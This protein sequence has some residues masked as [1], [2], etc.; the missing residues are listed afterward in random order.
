MKP[1]KIYTGRSTIRMYNC[2]CMELLNSGKT[3]D[4]AIVDPPY[5]IGMDSRK[6]NNRSSKGKYK[7]KQSQYLNK[8]WD[9]NSPNKWYH[10]KLKDISKNQIVW[11]A[12]YL[13]RGVWYGNK[14][15][16]WY[17]NGQSGA[18]DS[19]DCELACTSLDGLTVKM[20]TYDWV[21][22][23]AINAKEKRIHPTQ[24]P[25]QLYKWLLTNYAKEGDTI[26]D[27]HGGSMSIA[28]A[29][30][31]LGFDLDICELDTDYF[32]GAVK[33]FEQHISQTQLF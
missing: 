20:F 31:D 27:T 5:G 19:S 22:F 18:P 25:I 26:L 12:N 28:I 2:D 4:L 11:G 24:K 32:N 3:W 15:I 14:W 21:G 17:K 29:C 8:E 30:W 6:L 10:K 9:D 33:R 7:I 16:V 1:D 13:E 23:G